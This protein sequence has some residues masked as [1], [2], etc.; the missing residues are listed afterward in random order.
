MAN[1]KDKDYERHVPIP[2]GDHPFR[3]TSSRQDMLSQILALI[4][5][6]GETVYRG[7]LT[8]ASGMV[9][10]T[11]P[12][13]FYFVEQGKMVI[14]PAS[15]EPV[16]MQ[17]G[18]LLLLPRGDGHT[19]I[20]SASS[21][22]AGVEPLGPAHF[23]SRKL[24]QRCGNDPASTVSFIGGS[25][26]FDGNPL[27]AALSVLPG[28]IHI[29][30]VDGSAPEWLRGITHFLLE[31]ARDAGPGSSLMVSRLI[32]LL[33]IRALRT[34]AGAHTTNLARFAGLN[35]ER[36]GR[37]LRAMHDDPQ[38][39]W[40]LAALANVATMSRSL[41][42]EKFVT[43]VGEPPLRYLARWRLTLAADLL[44]AGQLKVTDVAHRTGYNS[45]GAFS[46][47][48]KA[49][50]GCPPSGANRLSC[51]ITFGLGGATG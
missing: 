39:D 32:D 13:H 45:V 7:E 48:F 3:W 9:L 22:D 31:E 35:E 24:F 26:F 21:H 27:T 25:F 29:R 2:E 1:A 6:R 43:A 4:R 38:R 28:V 20:D 17:K 30:G 49:Q 37:V 10:P 8:V 34:W 23:D 33:V 40:T 14:I 18:D 11:G 44:K 47:A 46:R 19:I 50:F 12:A 36:I 42:A 15:S 16:G 51:L 5:L 41:F